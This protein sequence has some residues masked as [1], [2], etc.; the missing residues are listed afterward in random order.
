M[1]RRVKLYQLINMLSKG[2]LCNCGA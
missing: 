1:I 2:S